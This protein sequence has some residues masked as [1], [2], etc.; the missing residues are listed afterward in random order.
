LSK[1]KDVEVQIIQQETRTG[2]ANA[3]NCALEYS[4]G[5]AI[6][7]SDA[8]CFWPSDALRNAV[9]YLADPI[10]GAVT[11]VHVI[12]NPEQTQ[13]TKTEAAYRDIYRLLRIGES[14]LH[15]TPLFEGEFALFRRNCLDRFDEKIGADDVAAA[16]AMVKKGYRAIAAPDVKFYE[17]TPHSWREKMRQKTRRGLHVIQAFVANTDQLFKRNYFSSL[18]L[19]MEMYLYLVNPIIW[20]TLILTSI[21][22]AFIHPVLLAFLAIPLLLVVVHPVTRN[23]LMTYLVSNAIMTLAIFQ[24]VVG[25]KQLAWA[26]IEETRTGYRPSDLRR[27][28]D[29]AIECSSNETVTQ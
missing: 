18:I 19:P 6:A 11:G 28:G 22:V 9:K 3:L 12:I 7:I 13:A 20:L 1:K 29:A 8:E 4:T 2:K 24:H 27:S 23:L 26:K 25:R 14:K 16:L 15:S 21:F 5:E 10:V 17:P